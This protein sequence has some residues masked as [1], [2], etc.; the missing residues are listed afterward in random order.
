MGLEKVGRVFVYWGYS[1]LEE[2]LHKDLKKLVLDQKE[3][4][5]QQVVF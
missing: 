2:G 4:V 3:E 1:F 5:F